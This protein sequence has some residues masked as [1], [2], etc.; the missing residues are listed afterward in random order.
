MRTTNTLSAVS[1]TYAYDVDLSAD[2]T[3]VMK[4]LKHKISEIDCGAGV[5]VIYDMG[6]IKWMLTTIQGELAT[7]IRMIQVPVTLVGV[8]AARK[9]ARVMD[10]DDVYHLVQVDLNQLNAEKTT[11]DELIITLCHTGEGGAAQL[12]DYIDQYSRLQMRVKALAIGIVMSWWQPYLDYNR[13]IRFMHL[14]A[15]LIL[16]YSAFR[17]FRWQQFLNIH[18]SS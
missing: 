17:L 9:S 18:I 4:A 10:V 11:K 15:P 3:M 2:G 8:D 6:A 13:F 1:N 5:L 7:K 14:S 16:N 12:K